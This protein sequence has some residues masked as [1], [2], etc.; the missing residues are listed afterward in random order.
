MDIKEESILGENIHD[1]WYYVS[2]G[3]AM[4]KFLS[5]ITAHDVIDVG[6]GSGI[7]SRQ[8][9][10]AG[11]CE[12]AICMD[13]N[14]PREKT[15]AHNGKE[16]HFV[17]TISRSPQHLILMMD[18][19]EHVP[20]DYTLLKRYAD[21][22]ETG[23]HLLIT[24]PAFPFMWSGHDVFL[25]HYRRYTIKTLEPVITKSG[26]T[27]IKCSYFFGILFPAIA[28]IRLL[29]NIL[30]SHGAIIAKSDLRPYP[31]AVNSLLTSLHDIERHILLDNNKLFGL[32][33]ICLCRK[34]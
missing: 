6:A 24:V 34:D 30:F 26:L 12:R 19:L 18:V 10:D 25:E 22:L 7:F 8:L 5:G 33:I 16:I 2:K 28:A 32:S 31:K 17:K 4:R 15:E 29:K 23:G 27:P 20:D 9:L 21:S 11:V 1:H 3:R 14:Y 13:P